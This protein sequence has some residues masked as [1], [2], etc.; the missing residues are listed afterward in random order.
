MPPGEADRGAR[1]SRV[2]Y[3]NSK[4]APRFNSHCFESS[5]SSASQWVR[6]SLQLSG[7]SDHV[8][9][10]LF[11]LRDHYQR[12]QIEGSSEVGERLQPIRL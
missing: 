6:R 1:G 9:L 10:V 5:V 3:R 12:H 2:E 8:L 4:Y 7:Q 11:D